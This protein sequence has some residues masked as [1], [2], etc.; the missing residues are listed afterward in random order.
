MSKPSTSTTQKAASAKN[1]L[2]AALAKNKQKTAGL[3]SDA[4][5]VM[6]GRDGVP[7]AVEDTV[8]KTKAQ[9]EP[10]TGSVGSIA[11]TGGV[12]GMAR[13]NKGV[14]AG[15][16]GG[17][18]LAGLITYNMLKNKRAANK[19]MLKRA[20]Y[21]SKGIDWIPGVGAWRGGK[22]LIAPGAV[23]RNVGEAS[24]SIAKGTLPAVG[25]TAGSITAAKLMSGNDSGSDSDAGVNTDKSITSG[26]KSVSE[27]VAKF[28]DNNKLLTGAAAGATGAA[29]L[30][31]LYKSLKSDD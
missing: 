19:P 13:R 9:M 25:A 21:V 24:K 30:Y 20:A 18:L 4:K 16:A 10:L 14:T 6:V 2:A 17:A 28:V 22:N 15:I 27:P 26:I 8:A 29:L 31:A 12:L 11:D 7:A 1:M 3:L 5:E 23:G